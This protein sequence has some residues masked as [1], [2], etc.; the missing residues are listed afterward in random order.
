MLLRKKAPITVSLPETGRVF[1]SILTGIIPRRFPLC[2]RKFERLHVTQQKAVA[3]EIADKNLEGCDI[4]AEILSNEF[5][6]AAFELTWKN[7]LFAIAAPYGLIDIA[8]KPVGRTAARMLA[9]ARRAFNS[10]R[11]DHLQHERLHKLRAQG[12]S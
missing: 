3:K 9:Q 1:N 2:R 10:A 6:D 11:Q 8:G 7:A 4:T 5:S 12:L